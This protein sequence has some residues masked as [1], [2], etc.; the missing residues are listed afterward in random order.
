MWHQHGGAWKL[1][2][3]AAR[4]FNEEGPATPLRKLL[5]SA[6][7][8]LMLAA[9]PAVRGEFAGSLTMTGNVADPN[10]VFPLTPI[11]ITVWDAQGYSASNPGNDISHIQ[12]RWLDS[13]AG[14]NLT[15]AS[16]WTWGA[17][18]SGLGDLVDDADM[19]DGLV[20]RINA[21][22]G[23]VPGAYFS[24]G[25]L[26]FAAPMAAGTY[27]L[28]LTGGHAGI[29]PEEEATCSAIADGETAL[30]PSPLGTGLTLS[31]YTFTVV[32]GGYWEGD[33]SPDWHTA[34]NWSSNMVPDASFAAT[35]GGA[36]TANQPTLSSTGA[37]LMLDFRTA[38]W[39]IY[40]G[41]QTLS[42]GSGGIQSAGTGSSTIEPDVAFTASAAVT[43]GVDNTL[44][45][46]ALN[47]GT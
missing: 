1:P 30:L 29:P 27:T 6:S 40:G 37:A 18:L 41:G 15:T 13:S 10:Y 19:S 23:I 44:N 11:V 22:D 26:A 43:V 21:G 36:P 9:A 16:T 35:F 5:F 14:L 28:T 34:G 7:V 46:A 31:G 2:P 4:T 42:V 20:M 17:A 32:S 12:L 24:M 8:A 25:T 38:G 45:T 39:T 33:V 47:A 3:W